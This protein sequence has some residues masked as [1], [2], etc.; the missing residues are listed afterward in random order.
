MPGQGAR[1]ADILL[2]C[3]SHGKDAALDVNVSSSPASSHVA[4]TAH[5]A[6]SAL[7]KA[8]DRKV[9]GAAE[10]CWQHGL[11]FVPLGLGST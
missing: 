3:W 1:P 9:Q 6:G 5:A 7:E 4:G 11:P 2:P 8:Y 10:A